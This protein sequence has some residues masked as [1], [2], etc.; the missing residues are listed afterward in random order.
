[1]LCNEIWRGEMFFGTDDNRIMRYAG[2]SDNVLLADQGESATA[3]DWEMLTGYQMYTGTP[4]FKRVQFL[5][6]QFV[7]TAKPLYAIKASYDFDLQRIAGSPPYVDPKTG[8]WNTGIWELAYWGGSYIVD[9]PPRGANGMGR[10]IA[11]AMK[12]RSAVEIIHVGTDVMIDK[13]GLL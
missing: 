4:E 6:P 12:G 8:L 2:F 13:G 10:H 9:Q 11:I 5:R 1:M 7:G 3:I